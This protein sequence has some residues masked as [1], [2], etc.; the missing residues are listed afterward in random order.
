MQ[1][2]SIFLVTNKFFSQ[3]TQ[4]F[5]QSIKVFNLRN[6]TEKLQLYLTPSCWKARSVC[7]QTV[8]WMMVTAVVIPPGA[9]APTSVSGM[10]SVSP[11][12]SIL[13]FLTSSLSLKRQLHP[14][15]VCVTCNSHHLDL[16]RGSQW[17]GPDVPGSR[18]DDTLARLRDM[19]PD[20]PVTIYTA[21]PW[22]RDTGFHL[23]HNP[24]LVRA[25]VSR[26]ISIFH[27]PRADAA[28]KFRS[29][30]KSRQRKLYI[31]LFLE[32]N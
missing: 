6:G 23:L 32:P 22:A 8:F 4:F 19:T 2:L 30:M 18:A 21:L 17:P 3:S 13:S 1:I 14:D 26:L 15:D 31:A 28:S 16:I 9:A 5:S 25:E 7:S 12:S 24:S 20:T 11:M 10:S 27:T 29:F